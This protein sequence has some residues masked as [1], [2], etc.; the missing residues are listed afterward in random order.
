MGRF[1]NFYFPNMEIVYVEISQEIVEQVSN[2]LP[3][4]SS[5]NF[6]VIVD[7]ALHYV[8][9]QI[10]YSEDR[11][12]HYDIIIH[13]AY[14][15]RGPVPSLNTVYFFNGLRKL[16]EGSPAS[17]IVL[18]NVWV[19]N[20]TLALDTAMKYKEVFGNVRVVGVPMSGGEQNSVMIAHSVARKDDLE[21][22]EKNICKS[23]RSKSSRTKSSLI[24]E[25][26]SKYIELGH[27]ISTSNQL[28]LDFDKIIQEAWEQ[29][30]FALDSELC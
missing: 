26:I 22:S 15:M 12:K 17:G 28:T 11:R 23:K 21:C 4:P 10:S 16:L 8:K 20:T 25:D 1:L 24:C 7:D 30:P 5:P 13:D 3:L 2:G 6:Q 19:L 14:D 27:T 9:T 18:A 29:R